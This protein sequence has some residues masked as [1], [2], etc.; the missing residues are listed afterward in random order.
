MKFL[1]SRSVTIEIKF[2]KNLSLLLEIDSYI[3]LEYIYIEKKGNKNYN[4][5]LENYAPLLKIE[6]SI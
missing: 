4:L 3:L 6:F 2:S 1:F 5:S